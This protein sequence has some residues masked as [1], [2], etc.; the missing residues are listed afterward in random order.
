MALA[1]AP[2]AHTLTLIEHGAFGSEDAMTVTDVA[3]AYDAEG[4]V[5]IEDVRLSLKVVKRVEVR[6]TDTGNEAHIEAEIA[7]LL[8]DSLTGDAPPFGVTPAQYARALIEMGAFEKA[9]AVT[10]SSVAASFDADV[11]VEDART[12]LTT[13]DSARVRTPEGDDDGDENDG[14]AEDVAFIKHSVAARLAATLYRGN[15]GDI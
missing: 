4:E 3:A 1:F 5:P 8:A 12:A 10:L 7:G 9:A 11:T 14:D 6:R 2:E 15:V 13:I